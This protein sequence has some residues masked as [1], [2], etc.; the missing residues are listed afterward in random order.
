MQLSPG[1]ETNVSSARKTTERDSS[2][3]LMGVKWAEGPIFCAA[4]G[5]GAEVGHCAQPACENSENT[6]FRSAACHL[7]LCTIRNRN[8]QDE[9][10]LFEALLSVCIQCADR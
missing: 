6:F 1:V 7:S 10:I 9:V 5:R 2:D 8:Q 4:F 3:F